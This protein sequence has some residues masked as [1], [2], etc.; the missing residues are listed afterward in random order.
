MTSTPAIDR[1]QAMTAL[2]R[3]VGEMLAGSGLRIREQARELVITNPQD[4][5]KGRIYIDYAEGQVCWTRTIW[6]YWGALEGHGDDD[7]S[8]VLA[9]RI[10]ATLTGSA[11]TPSH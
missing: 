5:D 9:A 8:E 4:P 7:G 11:A 1:C 10:I 2:R 6:D 3:Q